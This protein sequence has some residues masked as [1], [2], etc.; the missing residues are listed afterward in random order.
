MAKQV[1]MPLDSFERDLVQGST[2]KA[3][4]GSKSRDLWQV[5]PRE[6]KF[7]S[8]FNA[9]TPRPGLEAHIRALADSMKSEGYYMDKPIAVY[10][11]CEG[12]QEVKYVSDGHC[13]TKAVLL[14]I[15][16]GAE[17]E[18]IPAVPEERGVSLED[19]TVKLYRSNTGLP[20]TPYE[21]GLVCKRL[22]RY[23][24]E[25]E[26]VADRMGLGTAYV[27]GLLMLVGGPKSIRDA[28]IDDRISATEAVKLL[29]T[30]GDKAVE[31]LE[32]ML[33]AAQ[34]QGRNKATAKHAPGAAIK[35]VVKKHSD[36]LYQ[37]AKT[38]RQDPGY[39]SLAVET[40]L[41]LDEL[42]RTLDRAEKDLATE[43]SDAP[44]EERQQA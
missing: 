22:I 37:A 40:R 43:D 9:R 17:I 33:A 20:L 24:L 39:T 28:V 35:R 5:D 38:V 3:M 27:D 31:V 6:L 2:K 44:E 32:Q 16:E 29:K 23:G 7:M 10:I 42:L 11:A 26:V 13:R 34:A 19:L 12:D 25:L 4:S 14:A 36:S 30:H 1:E 21:T 41:L 15:Q 8:G 18:T